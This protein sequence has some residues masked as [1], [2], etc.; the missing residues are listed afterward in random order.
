[1]KS[2]NRWIRRQSL[3]FPM[4]LAACGGGGG[5]SGGVTA[6]PASD[7]TSGASV[8]SAAATGAASSSSST[9]TS[10]SSSS[11]TTTSGSSSGDSVASG[12]GASTAGSGG[13]GAGSTVMPV[14]MTG[15][16]TVTEKT[17][18]SNCAGAAPAVAPYQVTIK[19]TGNTLSVAAPGLAAVGSIFGNVASW[20][21]G[22]F[23]SMNATVSGDAFSGTYT[24]YWT[25]GSYSCSGTGS[26][27][28]KRS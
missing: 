16:W 24:W 6:A 22:G 17:T 15:T 7:S 18:D 14:D 8:S 21:G 10:G 26:V 5:D 13:A 12:S 2:M 25:D 1:M 27:N 11:G 23:T 9:T 3:I 19:Q 4:I 28:G 20:T